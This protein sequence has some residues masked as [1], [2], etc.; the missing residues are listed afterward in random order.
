MP[1]FNHSGSIFVKKKKKRN[2]NVIKA[3]DLTNSLQEEIGE[4]RHVKRHHG[5]QP[6]KYRMWEMIQERKPGFFQ[7]YVSRERKAGSIDW[8]MRHINCSVWTS[9]WMNNKS[10]MRLKQVWFLAGYLIILRNYL[11][12]L[13]LLMAVLKQSPYLLKILTEMFTDEMV[14][15]L[16]FALRN[17]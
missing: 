12:F 16:G 3:L 8:G 5:I 13:H 14:W 6:A 15:C 4:E 10:I 1:V 2:W 11:K 17:P 9:V 7:Q